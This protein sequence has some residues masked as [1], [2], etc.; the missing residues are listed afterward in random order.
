MIPTLV[1]GYVL[2]EGQLKLARDARLKWD[3]KFG[4]DT[5]INFGRAAR[6]EAGGTNVAGWERI[7]RFMVSIVW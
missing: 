3:R 6:S 5:K 2:G 1:A 4:P 7:E